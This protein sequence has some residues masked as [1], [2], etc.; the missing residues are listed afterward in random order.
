MKA[1]E[2]AGRREETE[3]AAEEAGGMIGCMAIRRPGT[4]I[5]LDFCLLW[6]LV[7]VTPDRRQ[8]YTKSNERARIVGYKSSKWKGAAA[9]RH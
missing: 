1:G 5:Y 6:Q 9:K 8:I 2:E 4:G 7:T 3:Q